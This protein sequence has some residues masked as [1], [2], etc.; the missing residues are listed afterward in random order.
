ME[1]A[2]RELSTLQAP[3]SSS[4]SSAFD[5]IHLVLS[6]AGVLEDEA[7]KP[8]KLGLVT[9]SLFGLSQ[10]QRERQV[11]MRTFHEF[12]GV[13]EEAVSSEISHSLALFALFESIDR[14]F[15]NL[16]RTV[17]RESSS[18]EA[19]HADLLSGLWTR[20]LGPRASE[21]LK[22]ERNRDLLRNVREKTV[23]NKGILVEHNHRLQTLKA[24]LEQLRRKL[25]SPLVRSENSSTVGVEEQIRGLE[26]VGMYL[27][28]VRRRQ[29]GK[30]MEMLY[31]SG[32]RGHAQRTIEE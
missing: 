19:A 15:L 29:K 23:R 4:L 18:Q 8:T 21:L 6:S 10:P 14:Q 3:S 13:L 11:L 12:L 31:G 30:L 17:T 16:A 24:N 1:W 25:V 22:Y 2:R 9:T 27:E 32:S 26:D 5:N 20:I 28:D 7:G